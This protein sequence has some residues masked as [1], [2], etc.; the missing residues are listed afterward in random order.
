MDEFMDALT[1]RNNWRE[2]LRQGVIPEEVG[3][4]LDLYRKLR[5]DPAWRST[6]FLEALGEMAL[7][8]EDTL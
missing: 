6:R 5:D 1:E 7:S 4:Q 8:Y 2:A 3:V